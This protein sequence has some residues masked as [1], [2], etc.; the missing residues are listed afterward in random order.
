MKR[1]AFHPMPIDAEPAPRLLAR[2]PTVL[3]A[4]GLGRSTIKRLI[5][6]G[7]FPSPVRLGRHAVAW[8]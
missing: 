7:F 8:R 2:L 5:A 4:T 1:S 6:A 3:R